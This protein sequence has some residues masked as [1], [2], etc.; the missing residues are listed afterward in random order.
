[1]YAIRSYYAVLVNPGPDPGTTLVSASFLNARV[2]TSGAFGEGAGHWLLSAR[3]CV[4]TSYS[5]H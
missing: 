1:M 4:I 2:Q 3:A 5:I